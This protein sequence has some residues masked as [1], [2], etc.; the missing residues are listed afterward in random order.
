[1][2]VTAA[3]GAVAVA[4]EAA[5]VA[6]GAEPEIGAGTEVGVVTEAGVEVGNAKA[7]GYEPGAEVEVWVAASVQD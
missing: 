4:A 3:I 6:V 2:A 5:V 1:M 7:S